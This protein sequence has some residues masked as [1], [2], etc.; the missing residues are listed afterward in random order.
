MLVLRSRWR[1]GAWKALRAHLS[2]VRVLQSGRSQKCAVWYGARARV[3]AQCGT[4][5]GHTGEGW[6][7]AGGQ[8]PLPP[9]GAQPNVENHTSAILLRAPLGKKYKKY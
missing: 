1:Q 9:L 6:G 5:I 7:F 3:G 4:E 2:T 8:M